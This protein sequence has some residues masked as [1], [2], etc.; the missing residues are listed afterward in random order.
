MEKFSFW[1]RFS[2]VFSILGIQIIRFVFELFRIFFLFMFMIP[3]IINNQ[4]FYELKDI[5]L[6]NFSDYND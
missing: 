1:Y 2:S 6:K 5:F 4:A 3:M